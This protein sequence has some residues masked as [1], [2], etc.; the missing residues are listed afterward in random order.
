MGF[1]KKTAEKFFELLRENDVKKVIDIRLNNKSQLAGFTKFPNLEFFLKEIASIDYEH[2][3]DLAP[4]K[5]LLD[6]FKKKNNWK[7]YKVQFN[8]LLVTRKVEE[9]NKDNF[10]RAC[11][12]CSEVE[13]DQCHRRLVA[14]YLKDRWKDVVISHL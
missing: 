10:D 5:E 11:L 13:P 6:K 14:G 1:T 7:D 12:L 9:K 4:T 8:E 3:L 2:E